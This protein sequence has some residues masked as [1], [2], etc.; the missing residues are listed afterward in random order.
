MNDVHDRTHRLVQ[1]YGIRPNMVERLTQRRVALVLGSDLAGSEVARLAFLTVCNLATRLGPYVPNLNVVVPEA[2]PRLESCLYSDGA[3]LQAQALWTL[4]NA[5]PMDGLNRGLAAPGEVH[6]V[7]IVLGDARVAADEVVRLGWAGWLGRTASTPSDVDPMERNPFGALT[8]AALGAAWLHARQLIAVGARIPDPLDWALNSLTLAG[9]PGGALLANQPI[10]LPRVLLVGG[11]ALGSTLTYAMAHLNGVSGSLD[12]VDHDVLKPTNAN[13]QITAPFER[14]RTEAIYKVNDLQLCWPA[15]RG[16]PMTYDAYKEAEGR[17]AGDFDIV[18][19]AVDNAETRRAVAS[20]L[21][22]VLIDGATGGTMVALMRGS[23]PSDSCVAC[24][25][26]QVE[27]DEDELWSTR[28]GTSREAVAA[29]R[30]GSL[31]FDDEVVRQIREQGT[32]PFDVEVE[33]ALRREGWS[34]L[35]RGRCGNVRPDRDVPSA[36]VSYVSAL[37]GF[38]MAAQLV[39]EILGSP[40]LITP[41]RWTWDDVLRCRPQD[42]ERV[43][44]D[45]SP[46][47][48]DHHELRSGIY[49]RRWLQVEEGPR[50]RMSES[51]L[52]G[53][54]GNGPLRVEEA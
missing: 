37:C 52:Q 19:T 20:D 29:L 1:L 11:G 41:P 31:A 9:E 54:A 51:V 15:V 8:A 32:L 12:V 16:F 33:Q 27:T 34:Y 22:R 46:S 6:E 24:T 50:S 48:A 2:A 44:A 36:S 26:A 14:A 25:Y 49:R 38:L 21:P 13:R 47:C 28:L 42:A 35:E 39:G 23:D 7:A 10:V 30:S 5:V 17:S 45:Q 53:L 4:R 18:I 43:G 3:S 40:S